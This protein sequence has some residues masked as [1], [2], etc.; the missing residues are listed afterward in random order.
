MKT[1]ANLAVSSP[2]AKVLSA[3]FC[4]GEPG[5]RACGRGESHT[6]VRLLSLVLTPF[7]LRNSEQSAE[8][9]HGAWPTT[10]FSSTMATEY[11]SW[12]LPRSLLAGQNL[13]HSSASNFL[14]YVVALHDG[15][16]GIRSV[17]PAAAHL[18]IFKRKEKRTR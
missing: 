8:I 1:F 14:V 11:G 6:C 12:T 2:F 18:R 10:V 13:T 17:V 15:L 16:H 4:A 3:N 9:A 7:L 5:E